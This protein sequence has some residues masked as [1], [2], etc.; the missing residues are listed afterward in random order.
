M[1]NTNTRT[2]M[3]ISISTKGVATF[4]ITAEYDTPEESAAQLAKAIDLVKKT[5]QEKGLS[6]PEEAA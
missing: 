4:D 2:R 5:C 1:E 6:L 3:S